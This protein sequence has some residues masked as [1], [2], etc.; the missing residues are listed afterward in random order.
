[1]IDH[2]L[3]HPGERQPIHQRATDQEIPGWILKQHGFVPESAWIM[4][5]KEL[6]DLARP[7]P[8]E[9]PCPPEKLVAIEQA[10]RFGL[11]VSPKPASTR[12]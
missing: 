6:S 1:M 4:H 9:N 7:E 11:N 12:R 8:N 5:C 10:F 2:G 3:R